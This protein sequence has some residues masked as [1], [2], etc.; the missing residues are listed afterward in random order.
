MT[1]FNA[2]LAIYSQLDTIYLG[3]IMI[4]VWAAGTAHLLDW[5]TERKGKIVVTVFWTLLVI[6]YAAGIVLVGVSYS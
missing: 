6:A 4:A 2:L 3:L 1:R 5:M